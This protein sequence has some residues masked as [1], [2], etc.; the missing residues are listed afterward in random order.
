MATITITR[1]LEGSDTRLVSAFQQHSLEFD[2][3]RG[4]ISGSYAEVLIQ[5][6][7]FRA[8]KLGTAGTVDSYFFDCGDILANIIGL[9]F[10]NMQAVNL[11]KEL[12]FQIQG[13]NSSGTV[14]AS[15]YHPTIDLC[16]A[17]PPLGDA[18]FINN[19]GLNGYIGEQY[20]HEKLCFYNPFYTETYAQYVNGVLE[21]TV[22]LIQGYNRVDTLLTGDGNVNFIGEFAINFDVKKVVPAVDAMDFYYIGKQGAILEAWFNLITTET[23]SERDNTIENYA[24]TNELKQSKTLKIGNTITTRFILKTIARDLGHFKQLQEIGTSFLVWRGSKAYR[25]VDYPKQTSECRQNLAFNLTLE[26]DENAVSY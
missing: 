14:I 22:D 15:A 5:G 11:F 18:T 26:T 12:I 13:K 21:G 25:V 9:Q 7:S 6:V 8:V 19:L 17:T 23:I 4:A 3:D 24:I 2:F 10:A 20:T 16:Y 1:A